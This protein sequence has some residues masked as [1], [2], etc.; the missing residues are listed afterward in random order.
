MWQESS[1]NTGHHHQCAVSWGQGMGSGKLLPSPV[2]AVG[3]VV[4]VVCIETRRRVGLSTMEIWFCHK[5]NNE[6]A[7]TSR[8]EET[9]AGKQ[10]EWEEASQGTGC[11]LSPIP[12]PCLQN[13][14]ELHTLKVL[15]ALF[16][17]ST[18]LLICLCVYYCHRRSVNMSQSA[19]WRSKDNFGKQFSPCTLGSRDYTQ[20]ARLAV[21][22]ALYPEPA[23]QSILPV[24]ILAIVHNVYISLPNLT[25]DFYKAL[26][27][28]CQS[29]VQSP[30]GPV[31]IP[32]TVRIPQAYSPVWKSGT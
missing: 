32:G 23:C 24:F 18:C 2:H 5:E 4:R 28:T 21:E 17:I 12:Y 10:P 26:S 30:T 29:Y 31:K 19:L 3:D 11:S 9:T 7:R 27:L 14:T 13:S 8:S 6:C 25:R 1:P 22:E 20:D 15:R 16:L